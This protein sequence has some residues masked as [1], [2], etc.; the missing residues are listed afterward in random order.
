MIGWHRSHQGRLGFHVTASDS[1]L[2]TLIVWWQTF[3]T[4][5]IH[6]EYKEAVVLDE[7]KKP[8]TK[9]KQNKTT[10]SYKQTIPE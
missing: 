4:T 8:K 5:K 7:K 3:D 10:T 1:M 6:T 9:T 2:I